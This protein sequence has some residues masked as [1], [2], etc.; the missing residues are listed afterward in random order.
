MGWFDNDSDEGKSS[1]ISMTDNVLMIPPA[2]AHATVSALFFETVLVT[3]HQQGNQRNRGKSRLVSS[4][5]FKFLVDPCSSASW[6][7]ELIAGAAS[8][9]A[10]KGVFHLPLFP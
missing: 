3:D 7:H 5:L 1:I 9:E 6:T 2:Q 10:A 4:A 8:Y